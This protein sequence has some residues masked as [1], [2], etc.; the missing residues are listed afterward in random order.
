MTLGYVEHGRPEGVPVLL[1]HGVTDSWRSF[2]HV[3][4]LLPPSLRAIAVTQRGHGDASRPDTY[5]YGD[6]APARR[7]VGIAA[8]R[9]RSPLVVGHSMVNRSRNA[10]PWISRKQMRRLVLLASFHTLRGHQVIQ[11]LWDT[12]IAAMRYP[13][14]PAFVRAFQ[15]GTVARPIASVHMDNFVAESLKVPA[16]A[17]RAPFHKF[18][19]AEVG[20]IGG[21]SV[22]ALVVSGGKDLLSRPQERSALLSAIS[23][24]VAVDYP[25]RRARGALGAS[26]G[27]RGRDGPLRQPV[28]R[29]AGHDQSQLFE[30]GH[31][32]G[33]Q[34]ATPAFGVEGQYTSGAARCGPWVGWWSASEPAIPPGTRSASSAEPRGWSSTCGGDRDPRRRRRRAAA[35]APERRPRRHPRHHRGSGTARAA[36]PAAH[37]PRHGV[38]AGLPAGAHERRHPRV[39]CSAIARVVAACPLPQAAGATTA[40]WIPADLRRVFTVQL[41]DLPGRSGLAGRLTARRH[42][43]GVHFDSADQLVALLLAESYSAALRLAPRS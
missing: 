38:R 30:G 28:A 32:D 5:H 40:P 6:M 10:W 24:A 13:I 16:R 15:E 12:G 37:A 39:A 22:P 27:C 21:I 20:A 34:E 19:D 36:R 11:E 26:G 14:D 7:G 43:R 42:R 8:L 41:R 23:G 25:G 3:L 33:D 29:P 18:L 17:W 9:I 2:E 35:A 4:P 1:L 31:G